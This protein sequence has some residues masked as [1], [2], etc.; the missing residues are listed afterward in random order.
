MPDVIAINLLDFVHRKGETGTPAGEYLQPV[1]PLY[2][3]PPHEVAFSNLMFY[4]IELPKFREAKQDFNDPLFL[5][6]YTI[7]TARHE[8][9]TIEEVVKMTP[10]LQTFEQKDAGYRQ[11]CEQYKR[12]ASDPKTRDEYFYWWLDQWK[13]AS[14]IETGIET[15]IEDA[16]R[17]RA[18]KD[19]RNFLAMGLTPEQ[20]AQGTE[21]P[22]SDVLALL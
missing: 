11:F 14:I 6:L 1:K 19:A 4:N 15:G 21:L 22:L 7:E 10:E 9:K 2:T 3:K 5:W 8:N 18:L 17:E 12:V 16:Q 20:V 13:T